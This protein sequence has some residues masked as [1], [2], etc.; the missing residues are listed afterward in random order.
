VGIRSLSAVAFALA[1]AGLS[2][3]QEDLPPD[4]LLLAR[5]KVH[6]E[7]NLSSLPNYT[8]LETIER[9]R[10]RAPSRRFELVDVLR[11]EV[12]LVNRKELFSWPGAGKFEESEIFEF[13]Q[14]GSIGNGSFGL[15]ANSVFL[16]H[17]PTFTYAGERIR[18]GGRKA[19][20]Y[21]YRVPQLNSGYSIRVPPNKAT[22]GYHGS[23]WADA[24]TLDLIR[25]EVYAD[26]IPP[27]LE[28]SEAVNTMEY[29]RTRIGDSEFLLPKESELL[30]TDLGGN[31]SRNRTQFSNC[32]QFAGESYLSF[33]EAPGA[34]AAPVPKPPE[35]V[36]LPG[37]LLLE[38][39]LDSD[40]NSEKSF[41]GDPITA[42]VAR[43]VRKGQNLIVPKGAAATG[44]IVR[45]ERSV[46]SPRTVTLGL[47]FSTLE[48][49]KKKAPFEAQL[50]YVASFLD[51]RE[52]VGV[53][54]QRQPRPGEPVFLKDDLKEQHPGLF[55][56][57]VDGDQLSLRRGFRMV[58]RTSDPIATERP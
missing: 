1:G 57:Q 46:G 45:M 5:I 21:D 6:M 18:E 15:H 50:E 36:R 40:I 2:L 52:T 55:Q 9:S 20:R 49:D 7:Q 28:V 19:V 47:Q 54:Y 39:E 11:L 22:V 25:L 43:T 56:F 32:R 26:D 44:R 27:I 33:G 41:V 3:A 14:G 31:E 38:L 10:R 58:F 34:E 35:P 48:F 8:C 13:V 29:A 53:R 17:A 42:K 51:R 12:A 4:V 23:F 30:M 24:E 37:G 16:S